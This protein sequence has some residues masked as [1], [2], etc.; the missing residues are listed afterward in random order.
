M[1][2]YEIAASDHSSSNIEIHSDGRCEANNVEGSDHP[3]PMSSTYPP[4]NIMPASTYNI[5]GTSTHH[6]ARWMQYLSEVAF[7]FANPSSFQDAAAISYPPSKVQIYYRIF[8][9][10]FAYK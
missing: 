3:M 7:C 1:N 9:V 4:N 8:Y 6:D 5:G 10:N 2:H